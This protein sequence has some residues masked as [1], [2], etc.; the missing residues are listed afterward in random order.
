MQKSF[1]FKISIFT[2]FSISFIFSSCNTKVSEEGLN[3]GQITYSIKYLDSEED[4]PVIT[5]LPT[6]AAVAF[7]ANKTA[8]KMVG[9][10]GLFSVKQITDRN[11]ELAQ[12]VLQVSGKKYIAELKGKEAGFGTLPGIILEK[13]N[14]E[15][16]IAGYMCNSYVAKTN[17]KKL[18]EFDVY[19]SDILKIEKPNINTP[20]E[21][22]EGVLMGFK[23][24]FA[25]VR[26]ELETTKV[27][28]AKVDDNVFQLPTDAEKVSLT[29][30]LEVIEQF[31]KTDGQN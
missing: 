27:I 3:E 17:I 10:M 20:F 29:E 6:S 8:F 31:T 19:Y 26:M 2:L 12:I 9:F 21:S 5:L 28:S 13:G 25:G 23:T 22:V 7:K 4:I 16:E 18:E 14:K 24:Q 1:F 11:N 30:L 15:K